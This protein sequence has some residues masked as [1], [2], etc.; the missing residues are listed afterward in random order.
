M[1]HHFASVLSALTL[2]LHKIRTE[3]GVD[4]VTIL[5]LVEV[6]QQRLFKDL[7]DISTPK[8]SRS[9]T[10]DRLAAG[11]LFYVLIT[12]FPSFVLASV[13]STR[14][15]LAVVVAVIGATII[16]RGGSLG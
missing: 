16:V 5:E 13:Q 4:I 8:F 10:S 1:L 14:H 6:A 9:Q 7:L 12:P 15:M 11:M 3:G 2:H